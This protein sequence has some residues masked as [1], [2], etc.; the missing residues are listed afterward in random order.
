MNDLLAMSGIVRECAVI[1]RTND[2][3][4]RRDYVMM[5]LAAN[6]KH[7]TLVCGANY[8]ERLADSYGIDVP[9]P[10][11]RSVAVKGIL[12]KAV[13]VGYELN[14]KGKTT[15]TDDNG[16]V[17]THNNSG[18][19]LRKLY[20]LDDSSA[21][22]SAYR[23]HNLQ[24]QGISEFAIKT[25]AEQSASAMIAALKS[26]QNTPEVEQ[27]IAKKNA[28]AKAAEKAQAKQAAQVP[29]EEPENEPAGVDKDTGEIVDEDTGEQLP[30]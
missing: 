24:Q 8:F 6:G 30:F 3:G 7:H 9:T 29:A 19:N 15:Y 2:A 12:N 4:V 28:I 16:V 27:H 10:D 5:T 13:E 18:N 22:S 21:E 1:P 17:K 14:I 25:A 26:I 20:V 11:D 23:A